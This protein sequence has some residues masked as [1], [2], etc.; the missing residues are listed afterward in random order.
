MDRYEPRI[1]ETVEVT[2]VGEVDRIEKNVYPNT[3]KVDVRVK[4]GGGATI[5]VYGV[6]M[7]VVSPHNEQEQKTREFAV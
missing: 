5:V 6:P 4:I 3:I 7:V 2:F 1:G